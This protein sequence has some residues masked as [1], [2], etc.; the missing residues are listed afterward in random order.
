MR[1]RSQRTRAHTR[2][3]LSSISA[4][5]SPVSRACGGTGGA[6]RACPTTHEPSR[7][8]RC[9]P[10]PS[11]RPVDPPRY[12]FVIP[13]F[14]EQET[15]PELERRLRAVLDGLD[16][17]AEVILVDDGSSDRSPELLAEMSRRDPRFKTI[18]FT[19]NF[20][21]QMAITAGLDRAQGDAVVVMDGDLQDPPELAPELIARWREGY[22]VVYAI[23][24]DR[25]V[26]PFFRR[27]A[28]GLFSRILRRLSDVEFPPDVGDFRFVDRRALDPYRLNREYTH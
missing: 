4:S 28:I 9:R 12:S 25:R 5:S 3:Y 6:Y 24:E 2:G 1:S 27:A 23:R 17:P 18:R 21:H 11:A 8:Y 16:G 10:L 13:V 22:E 14:D 26:E 20:G 7:S 19:R 15:L